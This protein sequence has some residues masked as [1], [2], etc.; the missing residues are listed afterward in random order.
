MLFNP[1]MG[2]NTNHFVVLPYMDIQW[3]VGGL[4]EKKCIV[5]M[6]HDALF[7]DAPVMYSTT[8]HVVC[9]LRHGT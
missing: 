9:I 2:K 6:V 7:C 4:L 8:E 3:F 1:I 5:V